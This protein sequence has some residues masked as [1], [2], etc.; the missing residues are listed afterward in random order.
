MYNSGNLKFTNDDM[1]LSP[2]GNKLSCFDLKNGVTST[3]P[4]ENRSNI[5]HTDISPDNRTLIT[6]DKGKPL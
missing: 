2:V 3:L 4:I 6:V 1:L 5:A